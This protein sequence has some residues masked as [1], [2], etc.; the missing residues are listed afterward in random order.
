M[1]GLR[2]ERVACPG[3][4]V[5]LPIP[6]ALGGC[7]RSVTWND[8]DGSDQGEAEPG[9]ADDCAGCGSDTPLEE[10]ASESPDDGGPLQEGDG[11]DWAGPCGPDM[12]LVAALGICIDAYEASRGE[13]GRA[14]SIRG[15]MPWT[16]LTWWEAE[17][18]CT[19]AGKRLCDSDEWRAACGGPEGWPFPYGEEGR[20]DY[21][22]CDP[23]YTLPGPYPGLVPTGSFPTCEG[24]Y[25]GLFD[26]VGNAGEW[27][28]TYR[29]SSDAG[30]GY[31]E[32]GGSAYGGTNGC[33]YASVLHAPDWPVP[34]LGFRCCRT[35]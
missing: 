24:G 25:A 7:Y 21:C 9:D 11:V 18:A 3:L 22:N 2:T 33:R 1:R 12:V 27:T 5:L 23:R 10:T 20:G 13:D 28:A 26:M 32:C 15:A 8:R 29:A 6:I 31:I 14:A 34:T 16:E 30:S 4:L 35:P 17:A 19:A